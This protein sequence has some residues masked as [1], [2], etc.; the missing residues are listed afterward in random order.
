MVQVRVKV[1]QLNSWLER[2]LEPRNRCFWWIFLFLVVWLIYSPSFQ[3]PFLYDGIPSIV[4]NPD[5]RDAAQW[6]NVFRAHDTSLQFDRRPVPALVTLVNYQVSG[7]NVYGYHVVNTLVHWLT[8]V[9]LGEIVILA[10]DRIDLGQKRLFGALTALLWAAHPMNSQAVVYIYQRMESIMSLFFVL[11]VLCHLKTLTARGKNRTRWTA[12]CVVAATLS[13]LSKESAAPLILFLPLAEWCL[14]KPGVSL[15][16]TIKNRWRLYLVLGLVWSAAL[17]WILTGARVDET[18]LDPNL[19]H[20]WAYLQVQGRVVANYLRQM[21]WPADLQ[22]AYLPRFAE[23]LVDWLP[24]AAI[25]VGILGAAFSLA[26]KTGHRWVLLAVLGFYLLLSPTS[27]VVPVPAEPRA[28]YR[29]YLPG[30]FVIVLALSCLRSWKEGFLPVGISLAVVLGTLTC[31]RC[32][33][34]RDPMKLWAEVVRN[35][36]MNGKGWTRLAL[37]FVEAG[38]LREAGACADNLLG[39]KGLGDVISES[40]GHRVLGRIA[41]RRKNHELA[42]GHFKKADEVYPERPGEN[43]DLA[44]AY[45]ES[46]NSGKAVELL[47]G[48][49]NQSFRSRLVLVKAYALSGE[50]RKS[51]RLLRECEREL[52]DHPDVVA[53]GKWLD[54]LGKTQEIKQEIKQ[55]MR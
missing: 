36:P 6:W 22:F 28:D 8:A 9:L 14:S 19:G 55:E 47:E 23:R 2:S 34:Y 32:Q 40:N 46:G 29:M 42:V 26:G 1:K 38:K 5:L 18:Q 54:S 53:L 33:V 35:E 45:L 20:P 51:V 37:G 16:Q 52:T 24:Y 27:S 48:V 17:A 49:K 30:I 4:E 41:M 15:M 25:H 39:L 3:V 21:F 7:L 44:R 12:G 50:K 31:K 11:A 43:I 10:C 13:I